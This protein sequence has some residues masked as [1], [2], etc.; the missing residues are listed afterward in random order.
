MYSDQ[1]DIYLNFGVVDQSET[2]LEF[3]LWVSEGDGVVKFDKIELYGA[4]VSATEN[5]L[6][7]LANA[8]TLEQ[9]TLGK[10]ALK[11]KLTNAQDG[12]LVL[13]LPYSDGWT[14]YID[15]VE[16][17]ILKADTAFMALKITGS[18]NTQTIVLRYQTPY[19][20]EGKAVTFIGVGALGCVILG[21]TAVRLI[22]KRKM[23]KEEG[24]DDHV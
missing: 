10:N 9:V 11:G 16:T 20:E 8:T 24:S 13:T 15:G 17:E 12:Y 2:S 18:S 7:M 19:L 4:P 23:K 22:K 3:K 5:A 21:D 1:R 6:D 14:A